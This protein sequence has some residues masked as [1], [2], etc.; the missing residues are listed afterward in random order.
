MTLTWSYKISIDILLS[1]TDEN[2]V[3]LKSHHIKNSKTEDY[4][5]KQLKEN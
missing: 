4:F 5:L 1:L 2:K 3:N